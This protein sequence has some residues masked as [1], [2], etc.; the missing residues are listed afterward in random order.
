MA[1]DEILAALD[2]KARRRIDDMRAEAEKEAERIIAEARREAE[3]AKRL[4]LARLKESLRSES[5]GVVYKATLKAKDKL[6][7][8]QEEVVDEA[9]RRAEE[10]L[11]KIH[12]NPEYADIFSFLLDEC[13]ELVE[14][15]III[16]VRE[17]DEEIARRLLD[18]RGKAYRLAES[19][20][21]VSGGVEARSP[22]GDIVI[23]NTFESRMDRA[24]ETL[25]LEIAKALFG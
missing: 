15:E 23:L 9:F 19:P 3:E 16:S 7:R 17:D 6:I 4:K 10:R 25:R 22:E 21:G 12:D 11:K 14:G 18:E 13:L 5:A 2:E 20:L 1:L 24:K 8:A